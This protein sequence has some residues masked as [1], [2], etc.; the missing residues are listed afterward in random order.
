MWGGGRGLRVTEPI[1]NESEPDSG[2]WRLEDQIRWYD[3]KSAHSQR[4]YKTLRSIQLVVSAMVPVTA[5]LVADGAAIAGCL[6]A[7][8]LVIEGFRELGA[9][10]RNWLKYRAT[11]ESLRHEKYLFLASAG[12]YGEID[13]SE[14]KRHLAARVE[15]L[16]SEEHSQ[17]A[18]HIQESFASQAKERSKG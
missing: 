3:K 16:V 17:W 18:A 13:P 15:A 8:L 9:Y 2:Y 12:P 11:C 10:H 4:V 7:L 6:G 1:N 5:F 14:T